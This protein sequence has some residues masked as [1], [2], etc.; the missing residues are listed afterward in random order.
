MPR[1]PKLVRAALVLGAVAA[2]H[3]AAMWWANRPEHPDDVSKV[4]SLSF[5]PD[6][7]AANPERGVPVPREQVEADMAVVSAITGK[8]RTYSSLEGL[9]VVPEIADRLGMKVMLGAWVGPDDART[10][11]ELDK[12]AELA[13]RHRSVTEVIVGNETLLRGERKPEEMVRFIREMRLRTGKPVS[14]AEIWGDWLAHPELAREVDFIAIHALP[15]WEDCP[16]EQA[17]KT[18][19]DH[20]D[21]VRRRYPN[22]RVV[23]AE[24]GWPSG[25]FN[26]LSS[27][28]S[29]ENEASAIRA[30]VAEAA[31]RRVQYNLIEAFDQPWK[32]AEGNV[33]AY[34]GLFDAERRLKFPLDG[35]VAADPW[36]R[37]KTAVGILIGLLLAAF[38][39]GRGRGFRWAE[40]AIVAA[41]GQVIGWGMAEAAV[42]PLSTYL[43]GGNAVAWA[44]G[45]PLL[46]VMAVLA[47]DRTREMAEVLFGPPPTGGPAFGG[48]PGFSPKVSIHVPACGEPAAMVIETLES[49]A[50]LDY[51]DFEV[52]CVINNTTKE[53]LIAPVREA[54][55][56]LGP[57]FKFIHLPEVSGFKAGALNR[58]LEWTSDDAEIIAV[59]DAD[60]VVDRDWLKD[61]CPA[62]A[63]PKVALVQA[64]QE[65][66]DEDAS[67]FKYMMNSEYKGFFDIGMVQRAADDAI[68]AHGTMIM[69]RRAAF[70]KVGR[71]SEWCICEDTELGLRLFEDGWSAV[72]TTRR[73]GRGILPDTLRAYR[74]QRDRWAYGA[75]RIMVH[76][77]GHMLPWRKGLTAAQKLH[78]CIGWLHWVGDAAA[79]LLSVSNIVWS[80]WVLGDGEPPQA[81]VAL[82]TLVVAALTVLHSVVLYGARVDRGWRR[83]P[84]AVAM[85]MSLQMT[86][87]KAVLS[88]LVV[89]SLPFNVTAKGGKTVSGLGQYLRGFLPEGAAAAALLASAVAIQRVN[90]DRTL[91]M[92]LFTAVLAVQSMPY[93][94]A[95]LLGTAELLATRRRVRPSLR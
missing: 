72:Y 68:V 53:E 7:A 51:P 42:A 55:A 2:L 27:V 41:A 30:F 12:A 3:A 82:G 43:R 1:L 33:G 40:G 77:I 65:H 29:L 57:R 93:L 92:Y 74:R 21:E 4:A 88:G 28:P 70:E 18:A 90:W 15:F 81:P 75:M 6:T 32:I 52:L 9:D 39:L 87:A 19:F 76:H 8:V 63:D 17:V 23:I 35:G 60:Y 64:P 91:E 25:K 95:F 26:R 84:S 79:L 22:K 37:C 20:Y 38:P 62:F 83:A 85:G 49:M 86:V 24:F 31:R 54:C 58:A 80:W 89:A 67:A 73:Y 69:V 45:A 56:I 10:R 48:G 36:W 44:V 61:L 78:F 94:S 66:R 50:R 16:A 59:V 34:W 47:F 46:A 5:V 13:K 71:W 14:S 11:A